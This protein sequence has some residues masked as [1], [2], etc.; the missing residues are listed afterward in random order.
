[1]TRSSTKKLFTPFKEPKREFQLSRKLLKTLSLDESRSH[2]FNLFSDLEEYSKEEVAETMVETMEHISD[3]EDANEHIEKDLEIIDL[4]HIPN[5]TQDHVM[6]RAF[7]MSLTRA[8]S[9]WLRNKP[10][11]SITTWEDRNTKTK[12]TKTFDGLAAIQA[13]LNNLGREIKKVNEKVYAAQVGCKQWGYRAADP[14]FYQRN[15]ANPSYQEQRQSMEETL[16]K[17]MSESTKRRKENYDVLQEIGFGSLPSSTEANPRDHVKSISTT[18]GVG[19]N[20]I[21]RIGSHQYV[22]KKG[23]YGPQFSKD[24][25]YGASH[26]NN[27]IPQKEKDPGSFTLPCYINN[28]CFDNALADLGASLTVELADRTVKYPKGIAENVLVGIGKFIFPLDFIILDMPEVVKVPLILGRPFLSTAH[29]K[30]DMFKKKITLRVGDEK[31]IFK[32]VKPASSMIK[33]VY[34][35][36]L[37]ERMELDL[38]ARLMGETLVL[39]RTLDP[40]YGDYIELNDLNV[41]LELR[42]DQVDD[43]MPTIE[44]GE[45]ATEIKTWE[46]LFLENHSTKLHAWKQEGLMD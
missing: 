28:V 19:S 42:R 16:S 3:H 7:L 41:P 6:L 23:S 35:L 13:R 29:D 34:I 1:M 2:E 15:N 8:A 26:I 18:A 27:S 39:N 14:G 32:S 44:E 12:S 24:Y 22:E 46:I 33:R 9:R 25:S 10:S 38:K 17:F 37:S 45:M 40:L 31:I 11:G 30:I 5:I 36:S 43:L 21:W 4:F 20:P